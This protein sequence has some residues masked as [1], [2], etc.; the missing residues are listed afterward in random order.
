MGRRAERE[1]ML[2]FVRD[3]APEAPSYLWW[4]AR[5]RVGKTVMLA[6][7]VRRPPPNADVLNF[8]VSEA[9]GTNTRAAFITEMG[10]Q[11]RAF[12]RRS[13]SSLPDPHDA[14]GWSRL[15]GE[16]AAKSARH[17]RKL[18]LV[19]DGLDEDAA[20]GSVGRKDGESIAALL[21]VEPAANLRI[22]VSSRGV[23]RLPDDLPAGHPLRLREC[24]RALG[25]FEGA[26]ENGSASREAAERLRGNDLGRAVTDLL[27]VAGGGLRVEDLAELTGAPVDDVDGLLRSA[28]GRCVVSSEPVTDP[29]AETYGLSDPE[30]VCS[31]RQELGDTGVAHHAG[32]LHAWAGRW[33]VEG[34]PDGTPPYLLTDYLR[35]LDDTAVRTEYVLDARRQVR[36]AAMAGHDVA[37]AQ[38][39]A[40]GS[41]V[42][43]G[44]TSPEHL[45]LALRFAASRASML[46]EARQVPYRAPVL[47]ARLGDTARARALARSASNPVVKAA[48]LAQVAAELSRAGSEEAASIAQEAVNWVARADRVRPGPPEVGVAYA[49]IAEAAHELHAHQETEAAYAL[50]KAV[51]LSGEA[52]VETLIAAVNTLPEEGDRSWLRAVE[53]RVDDLSAGKPKALAAAVDILAAIASNVPS[54]APDSRNRIKAICEDVDTSDGLMTVDVLSLGA[55]A[56]KSRKTEAL[57]LM[58]RALDHLT[59][60]LAAPDELSAADQAHLR[61]EIST[62]LVRLHQA[63]V[64][65]RIDQNSLGRI[66][67]LVAKHRERLRAGVLGDDL[68]ERMEADNAEAR[69]RRA[70]EKAAFRAIEEEDRKERRRQK[71]LGRAEADKVRQEWKERKARGEVAPRGRTEPAVD[72]PKQTD[73]T[74]RTNGVEPSDPPRPLRR[75]LR[76]S[77]FPQDHDDQPGDGFDPPEHVALLGQAERLLADGNLPLGRGRLEEALR[78]SPV[79]AGRVTSDG[80]WPLALAQALGAAGELARADQLLTAAPEPESRARYLAALSLGCSQGGYDS[81]AVAYAK[82]AARLGGDL[83]DPALRGAIAQALAHAGEAAAA[84]GM[85]ERKD[86]E[87]VD[88]PGRR[89]QNNRSLIAVAAGLARRVPEAAASLV[90]QQTEKAGGQYPLL[91]S[92][93]LLLGFPDVRRPGLAWCEAMRQVLDEFAEEPRQQWH[94]PSLAVLALLLRLGCCPAPDVLADATADLRHT[95]SRDQLPYAE[96]AVLEAVEGDVAEARRL[97]EAADPTVRVVALA[98]VATHLAG[99]PVALSVDPSSQ[100]A[101]VRLCLALA[102]AAGDGTAPDG[103]TAMSV[104]GK[105]VAG[106]GAGEGEGWTYA[107]PLLPRLAPEALGPLSELAR[108]HGFVGVGAGR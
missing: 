43:E 12:L 8:F 24:L 35:L 28:D 44:A 80:G 41:E 66:E 13:K 39:E 67:E 21:P 16:A 74:Q 92:A 101:A 69:Q 2:G 86:P 25:A 73:T 102:H 46:R 52:D 106:A 57:P 65:N 56:L 105:L 94:A 9:S 22:I 63:A 59:A 23:A 89:V 40:L 99:A 81:A 26:E 55:S 19:V 95:L 107:I 36:L 27:A 72:S 7:C 32:L 70:A 11:V 10:Q 20:W 42:G 4:Y 62:T 30:I 49:E 51:V 78:R 34:W 58:R 71:D 96:L 60:A 54:R 50:L 75:R 6:D 108:A 76:A 18:L 93:E 68:A 48:R 37:L 82:E 15:F 84:V 61:R 1:V 87:D 53:A 104:V 98:A 47:Y 77:D 33:R 100:D 88:K 29:A 79:P 17:G 31:V 91:R 90:V 103:T 3:S 64:D 45:G 85:A 5:S 83:H 97:A 38:M 14:A